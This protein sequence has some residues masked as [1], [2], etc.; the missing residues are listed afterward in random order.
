MRA[1]DAEARC[2]VAVKAELGVG[3]D[4]AQI[5]IA[6]GL[7][8]RIVDQIFGRNQL[9]IAIVSVFPFVFQA[10]MGRVI[11]LAARAIALTM[12]GIDPPRGPARVR[13]IL[14]RAIGSVRMDTGQPAALGVIGEVRGDA[15]KVADLA[16]V[17][18]GLIVDQV[19][20]MSKNS[21]EISPKEVSK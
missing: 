19:T 6:K 13:N 9:I 4:V 14:Q 18:I 16:C 1:H 12:D 15:V 10:G 8:E 20:S 5:V 7:V 2:R 3:D 21:S 17:A 11:G